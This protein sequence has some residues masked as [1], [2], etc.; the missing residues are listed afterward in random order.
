MDDI[1]KM[2]E[3]LK[4]II[5]YS[6]YCTGAYCILRGFRAY[7]QSRSNPGKYMAPVGAFLML[8]SICIA[9]AFEK[10]KTTKMEEAFM[11][12]VSKGYTIYLNGIEVDP[13]GIDM[14]YYNMTVDPYKEVIRLTG[15]G[16][17]HQT[18]RYIPIVF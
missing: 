12:A 15:K 9:F 14:E 11:Y 3:T 7:K 16:Y 18:T 4:V 2:I 6:F 5:T 13:D 8:S 17:L 10:I 1:I